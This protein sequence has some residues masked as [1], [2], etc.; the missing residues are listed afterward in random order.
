M[1]KNFI[2]IASV[3]LI[4]AAVLVSGCKKVE[5]TEN[6]QNAA[7][8]IGDIPTVQFFLED[9]VDE[10]DLNQIILAG[11]NAQSGMNGQP[12]HF[13]IVKSK[14]IQNQVADEMRSF[15][16]EN[17]PESA[18]AKAGFNGAPV[19]IVVSGKENSDFDAAL[20]S[21][22]I[23]AEAAVLGYGTKIIASPNIVFHGEKRA[24][25]KSL[26]KI[27]DDMETIAVVLI[28]KPDN[29]KIDALSQATLRKSYDEVVSV[30]E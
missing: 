21:Q 8:I 3:L 10:T 29:E 9:K 20:A 27:P 7:Q 30:I 13:S 2:F 19:A 12:W 6:V 28:G 16:P 24:E 5:Q 1:K 15:M 14:A 18:K 22:A 26:L 25:Y 11:I 23:V 4:F 17:L